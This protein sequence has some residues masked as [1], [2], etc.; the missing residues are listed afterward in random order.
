MP[1][2]VNRVTLRFQH[3]VIQSE[4]DTAQRMVVVN[5]LDCTGIR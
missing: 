5:N 1:P 3:L 2:Y 4:Q